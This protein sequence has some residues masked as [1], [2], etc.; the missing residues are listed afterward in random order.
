MAVLPSVLKSQ[1][2]VLGQL[3]VLGSLLPPLFLSTFLT[4]L[5]A[6]ADW[7]PII[8]LWPCVTQ[9]MVNPL[10]ALSTAASA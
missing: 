10:P 9:T 5:K 1:H 7:I 6:I 4:S 2:I 3:E 8:I